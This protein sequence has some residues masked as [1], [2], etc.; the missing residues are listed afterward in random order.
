RAAQSLVTF[1]SG[2][3]MPVAFMPSWAITVM[4]LTPFPSM[5]NTPVEIYLG[6]VNGADL[7]NALLEQLLWVVVMV[8]VCRIVLAAGVKRLVIQGG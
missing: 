6:L 3:L 8:A 1:L 5:V 4:R 7:L 2:F